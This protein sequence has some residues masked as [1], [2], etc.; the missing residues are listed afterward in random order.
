MEKEI[1][2]LNETLIQIYKKNLEFLEENFYELFEKLEELS[3]KILNGEFSPKYSLEYRKGYFD[4]LNLENNSW[5]YGC[6][7]YDDADIRA[8]S[9]NFTK[10]GS[11]DL[12]RKSG[13]NE[14]L[15]G[16]SDLT[17]IMPIISYINENVDLKN[18]VFEK[19]Y[20]F[21]FL[22]TGLGMHIN[23]IYKKINPY[24]TLI[25]EPE[26]EVFRLSLFVTDYSEFQKNNAKLFLS[27]EED[28]QTR[29]NTIGSFYGYHSYMNYNVKHHLLIENDR[30]L[31]DELVDF[32]SS[33]TSIS[34][35][36]IHIIDNIFKTL[37]FVDKGYKF[38]YV[39]SMIKKR[40]LE[41]KRVLLIAAGPSL[42][43]YIEWIVQ[44]QDKFFIVCVDVILRK[45]E[46]NNI[47]PD[48]VVSIDPAG[49]C[50]KY[51]ATDDKNYLKNSVV[52]MMSQQH[53]DVLKVIKKKNGF[54]TQ[55]INIIDKLGFVG[56]ISNVGAF[57]YMITVH[58]GAKEIYT[59]GNDAAFDQETR[60]RYAKDSTVYQ[61]EV[62]ENES[63]NN[64]VVSL[65]DVIEVDGNLRKKVKTNRSLLMFK[66]SFESVTYNLQKEYKY[67]VFNLSD[68]VLIE[69]MTPM[70]QKELEDK[71]NKNQFVHDKHSNI[72]LF[73]KIF[74]KSEVPDFSED[75]KR[76]Y[77][78]IRR[79]KKHKTID[80]KS[81]NIFLQH[82]L[83]MM[84]WLLEESKLM[85]M[86]PF[87]NVFLFYTEIV[88]IYI[89]L[90]LN[91][92]QEN[93]HSQKTLNNINKMWCDG[94]L[95]ILD[96]FKR[97]SEK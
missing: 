53:N 79:V 5:Y 36:Y 20:K 13:F 1:N 89:N 81:K 33:N 91:L 84:I 52:V 60:A 80:M 3:Q 83:D 22:G 97:I 62:T 7:S 73:E 11:L 92:K 95:A 55:S 49:A 93:L 87:G 69:K 72:K 48:M 74:K 57:S 43:N 71:M 40:I 42:D 17:K 26:L 96:D 78:M 41:T 34:F 46:K 28:K 37:D 94:V 86:K 61:G 19:I 31:Y 44:N 16:S 24:T 64:G 50:A 12:L 63:E 15:A 10:D 25:I 39:E 76:I 65:H 6:N 67:E 23:E 4:I 38:L 70:T 29:I 54:F 85:K 68:G 18:I 51:L 90:V 47:V 75:K 82:K 56:S 30:Y 9:A 2:D 58:F 88:D 77:A 8:D 27:I 32:F 66:D 35:P 45:L 59:I 21:V 14:K